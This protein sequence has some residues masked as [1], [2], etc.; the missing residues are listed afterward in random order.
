MK[1]NEMLYMIID[2]TLTKK[3]CVFAEIKREV[4]QKLGEDVYNERQLRNVLCRLVRLEK[5]SKNHKGEYCMA[6]RLI[7]DCN[8]NSSDEFD[9]SEQKKVKML[10]EYKD[11]MLC[12]CL[13]EEKRLKNPFERFSESEIVEAKRVYELNKKIIAMLKK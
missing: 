3:S 7:K 2:E 10:E 11:R 5:I 1:K 12:V 4:I 9:F 13:E 8:E 6:S